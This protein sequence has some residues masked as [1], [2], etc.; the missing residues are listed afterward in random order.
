M[1]PFSVIDP[2]AELALRLRYACEAHDPSISSHLD[3]VSTYACEIGRRIGLGEQQLNDLRQATPLHDVG[4]IALPISLLS[5]P[6]K[7]TAEE[8]VQIRSHTL[9]GHRILQHSPWPV[10]QCAARI[11]LAHHEDWNGGGYP[12][13]I[14]GDLIPLD[15]R[16]VAVAD[17]YDALMSSRAYKPAWE[18]DRVLAE[19]KRLRGLKFDPD[20]LDA[21]L[22]GLPAVSVEVAPAS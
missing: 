13:G 19:M 3:R 2:G 20:I 22:E 15:A 9:V 12:N 10:I 17:V 8:M 21:F 1:N 5:K 16:I 18:E 7:L 14:A 6:G 11:A 4:K